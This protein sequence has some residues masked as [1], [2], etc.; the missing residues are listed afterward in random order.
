M[1]YMLI[2]TQPSD[3]DREMGQFWEP[4]PELITW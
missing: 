4:E 3:V 1:Q 2:H